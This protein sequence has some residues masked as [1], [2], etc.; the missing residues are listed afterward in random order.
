MV[1]ILHSVTT[2]VACIYLSAALKFNFLTHVS[3]TG[4]TESKAAINSIIASPAVDRSFSKALKSGI[5]H[6][7][8]FVPILKTRRPGL[9]GSGMFPEDDT[10]S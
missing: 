4:E 2:I 5:V 3:F 8:Y 1:G 7:C 6:Y 10:V 9:S